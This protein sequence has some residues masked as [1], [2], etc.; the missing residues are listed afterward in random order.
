ML[1]LSTKI[2]FLQ[3]QPTL[4]CKSIFT[5]GPVGAASRQYRTPV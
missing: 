1:L 3:A 4:K 2:D 5:E